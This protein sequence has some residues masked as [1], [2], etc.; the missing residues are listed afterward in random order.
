MKSLYLNVM[1]RF[2]KQKVIGL[3]L[4]S[5]M[6]TAGILIFVSIK[7][8]Y[9]QKM[10]HR[11]F[12]QQK[13]IVMLGTSLTAFANW[14]ELLDRQDIANKG[15]C[16]DNTEG[17]LTR[18]NSVVNL[19]PEICFIEGGV[20]DLNHEVHPDTIIQNLSSI[21]DTLQA[22][23]IKPVLTKVTL[24]TKTFKTKNPLELNKKIKALNKQIFRLAKEKNIR[25]IDLNPYVSGEHFLHPG[26]A[27]EDGIHFTEKTYRVWKEEVEKILERENR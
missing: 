11:F 12:H 13:N 6:L 25:F 9:P 4:V 8:K 3:L 1:G 21:I 17:F 19:K 18:L 26:Y 5:S 16:G 7:E 27:L 20:N 15:I 23:G 22:H 2:T 24:L 14:T 10:Y